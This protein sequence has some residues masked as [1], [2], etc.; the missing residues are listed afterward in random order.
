MMNEPRIVTKKAP[1]KVNLFLHILSKRSDDFHEL[2]SLISFTEFGDKVTVWESENLEF[3]FEGPMAHELP[4]LDQNIVYKAVML[5]KKRY[6][7]SL[8]AKII[9][10][11]N[12]PIAGGLGGGTSDAAAVIN[13]LIDLWNIRVSKKK[14]IKE[15][16]SLGADFPV[17]FYGNAA[18][19]KGIG[20]I[21][22][23]LKKNYSYPVLLVN[24][25]KKIKY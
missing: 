10:E 1:A 23:P 20:D 11:K 21:C 4:P 9:V 16:I 12:I 3:V 15:F 25:K 19:V 6:K 22:L 14:L 18:L 5:L 2:E 7:V 24:P 8:G 13:C 17:C